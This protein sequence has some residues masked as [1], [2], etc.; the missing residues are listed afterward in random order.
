MLKHRREAHCAHAYP[1]HAIAVARL[2]RRG[3]EATQ[4]DSTRIEVPSASRI[5]QLASGA[6]SV[7]HHLAPRLGAR[8]LS[9]REASRTAVAVAGRRVRGGESLGRA[10]ALLLHLHGPRASGQD[11]VSLGPPLSHGPQRGGEFL[12]RALSR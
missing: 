9:L 8:E 7:Q 4:P 3:G 6:V 12:A 5:R 1:A 10:G 11:M 2:Q